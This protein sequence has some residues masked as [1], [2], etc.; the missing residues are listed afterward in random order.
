M[1]SLL[2]RGGLKLAASA[3]LVEAGMVVPNKIAGIGMLCLAGVLGQIGTIQ[4]MAGLAEGLD[5]NDR[6][7]GHAARLETPRQPAPR[8]GSLT[9]RLG[10]L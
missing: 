9:P 4:V 6:S 1:A 10:S 5:D 2:E 7:G 3:T 8:L